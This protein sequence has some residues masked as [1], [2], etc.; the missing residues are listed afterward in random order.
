MILRHSVW[1]GGWT[2][3]S[4]LHQQLQELHFLE[5]L[6]FEGEVSETLSSVCSLRTTVLKVAGHD[7]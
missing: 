3:T 1:G 4:F 5:F 7:Q 2:N 6:R